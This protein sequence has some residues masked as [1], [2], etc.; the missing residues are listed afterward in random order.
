M[1][2]NDWINARLDRA[3]A[4]HYEAPES[5]EHEMAW[6]GACWAEDHAEE[7]DAMLARASLPSPESP[8]SP[9]RTEEGA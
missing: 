5:D 4:A 3:T 9:T 6:C 7:I 8:E 1:S 2:S